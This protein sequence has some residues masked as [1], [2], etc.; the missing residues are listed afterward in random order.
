ML[1]E[2]EEEEYRGSKRYCVKLYKV[3]S[4]VIYAHAET[5]LKVRQS[6]V[7]LMQRRLI[8]YTVH[9]FCMTEVIASLVLTHAR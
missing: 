9:P 2:Y 1:G 3:W 5:F 7:P 4:Q 8:V 6:M